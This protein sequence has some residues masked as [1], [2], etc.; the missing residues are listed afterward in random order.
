MGRV[1]LAAVAVVAAA[2][3]S[4]G[5]RSASTR[6]ALS[7]LR[8]E[9]DGLSLSLTFLAPGEPHPMDP[10]PAGEA[11]K[12]FDWSKRLPSIRLMPGEPVPLQDLMRTQVAY[13]FDAALADAVLEGLASDGFFDRAVRA[14]ASPAEPPGRSYLLEIGPFDRTGGGFKSGASYSA[15]LGWGPGL[16]KALES[17]RDRLKDS[18]RDA[19][20]TVLSR[21]SE[22][23]K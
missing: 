1:L 11:R 21:L 12:P 13:H 19:V 20:V 7:V 10:P 3:C 6:E 14:P 16:V 9:K 8:A 18:P 4:D 17:L 5:S 2:G 23:P 15:N 22:P